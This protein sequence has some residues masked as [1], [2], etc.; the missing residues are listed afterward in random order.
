MGH[1]KD[2]IKCNAVLPGPVI[3]SIIAHSKGEVPHPEGG[4][5]FQF[6]GKLVLGFTQPPYVAKAIVFLAGAGGANGA[7]LAIDDAFLVR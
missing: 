7:E 3:T 1:A 2:G 4:P 6:S 5:A